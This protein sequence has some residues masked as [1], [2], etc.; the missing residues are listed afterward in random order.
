VAVRYIAPSARITLVA[1]GVDMSKSTS[2]EMVFS[3]SNLLYSDRSGGKEE[4]QKRVAQ[5]RP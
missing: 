2:K 3:V 1:K 5:L 4:S